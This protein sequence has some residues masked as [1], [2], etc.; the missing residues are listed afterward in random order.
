MQIDE[1]M[2]VLWGVVGLRAKRRNIIMRESR[3]VATVFVKSFLSFCKTIRSSFYTTKP[4]YAISPYN[5]SYNMIF[6]LK[7]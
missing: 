5:S 6:T 1:K 4:F 2:R 7:R 3:C